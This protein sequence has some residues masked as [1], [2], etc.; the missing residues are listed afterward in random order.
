MQIELNG[1][2]EKLLNICPI[3]SSEFIP[4]IKKVHF[5][6]HI[7]ILPHYSLVSISMAN[8]CHRNAATKIPPH[9]PPPVSTDPQPTKKVSCPW[10]VR[11]DANEM[12]A[13]IVNKDGQVSN[14]E[15]EAPPTKKSKRATTA[16]PAAKHQRGA[17]VVPA[18]EPLLTV[19]NTLV[20]KMGLL[21]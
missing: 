20:C 9:T 15:L 19:M 8:T 6:C 11:T 7:H 2:C 4:N 12:P 17:G 13:V 21:S 14:D 10:K 3:R 5:P 18:W 16:K 1:T